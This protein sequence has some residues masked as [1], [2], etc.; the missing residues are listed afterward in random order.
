MPVIQTRGACR[1]VFM[2]LVGE[3]PSVKHQVRALRGGTPYNIVGDSESG[4]SY[5]G[6]FDSHRMI[7][8]S[9]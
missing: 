8:K 2:F 7:E 1:L 3:I 6:G 9:L 4:K 5:S